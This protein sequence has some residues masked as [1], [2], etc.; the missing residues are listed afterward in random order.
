M[1]HLKGHLKGRLR[2]SYGTADQCK[3]TDSIMWP[4]PIKHKERTM[5]LFQAS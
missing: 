2:E 5:Q 1:G 3:R 4:G